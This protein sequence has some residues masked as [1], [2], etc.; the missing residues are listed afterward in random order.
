MEFSAG[1]FNEFF[2]IL[3]VAI[4]TAFIYRKQIKMKLNSKYYSESQSMNNEY[5]DLCDELEVQEKTLYPQ[6]VVAEY[7]G[8]NSVIKLGKTAE[9]ML[10]CYKFTPV[11]K[12]KEYGFIKNKT[13]PNKAGC[14]QTIEEYSIN[15]IMFFKEAGS[16][17]YTT[18][19]SG[20]GVNVGGA[21]AGGLI[22]G[23]V[24]A[25]IGSRQEITS[26][27]KTHDD[28]TVLLK[29]TNGKEKIFKYKY[30]QGF[31]ELIPE[32][33]YSFLMMKKMGM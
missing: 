30:Y 15:E 13:E 12:Y 20:G 29:F 8:D 16:L 32:K 17:Q 9:D 28:R 27:T 6:N 11:K 18:S 21:I 3:F 22:G 33:E 1:F 26:K 24:G 5:Y 2:L 23:D 31:I 10:V 19:V 25:I 4:T 14:L 7:C